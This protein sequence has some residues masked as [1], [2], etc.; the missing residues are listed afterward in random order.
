MK[1]ILILFIFFFTAFSLFP[2]VTPSV[3]KIYDESE[4]D[5]LLEAGVTIERRRGDILLCYFPSSDDQD[6]N[7]SQIL[8]TRGENKIYNYKNKKRIISPTLD[9]AVNYFDA[10]QIQEGKNF[11]MPFTGKGII[12]GLCDI[13][14]DPLHPTFLDENGKSRIKQITQYKEYDGIKIELKGDEEYLQWKTDTCQE[15]HATHVAGILGG[16][17]AGTPYKGIAT[18]ADIVASVSCLSDF[19]ILMGVED[20]IDYAKEVGKPA[21]INLSVGN[22]TG[23]HDGTSLFSQYL[24]MCADDAIIVLSAGNE[25]NRTNNLTY[26]FNENDAPLEFII[27]NRAW[28]QVKMRGITDIWNNSD[29]PLT[30]SVC[31]FDD[32]NKQVVYQYDPIK[33][34]NWEKTVYRWDS[35]NPVIDELA[36]NGYLVV[37]AG[38]DPENGRYN[39]VIYYDY[40]STHLI[41][42]GSG[43]AKDLISFKLQGE[44]GDD[45]DI[46]ADGSHTRL[47]QVRGNPAPDSHMSISDLA[48]GNRIISVGMYGNRDNY[49][50]SVLD[51][52]NP[53]SEIYTVTSKYE[54]FKTVLPSSFGKL[55]DERNLPLTVAP[56]IPVMSSISRYYNESFPSEEHL[57]ASNGSLWRGVGGTSMSSPY[58]AGYIATWLEALPGLT[59]EDILKLIESSN[60]HDIPEPDDPRNLNGYFDPVKALRMAL[61]E[62]GI[63]QIKNPL[64]LLQPADNVEIFDLA[65]IRIYHGRA[66][67][68]KH[69]KNGLFIIKTPY[70]VIKK[71]SAIL[72]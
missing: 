7:I 26:V 14:L 41:G 67:G 46:F 58:V 42:T 57:V 19:G 48:T 8:K 15:Y 44:P 17:G 65:G 27:G 53:S 30:I 9:H 45:I 71:T 20:I 22:Y 25:G 31:I 29:K 16:R 54:A 21:V 62:N 34:N 64:S 37:T 33:L 43:W 13:G 68:C 72:F 52:S 56:G 61:T 47:M 40:T 63:V 3:I 1:K 50:S 66:D 59:I 70:G 38:I 4:I 24:D 60:T 32:E 69:D 55:R 11:D 28:D 2:S 35:E 10:Y 36:L 5:S 23:A 12:V 51:S 6:D 39:L 18:D 49:P